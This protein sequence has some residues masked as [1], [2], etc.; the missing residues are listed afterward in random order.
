MKPVNCLK[1]SEECWTSRTRNSLI[2]WIRLTIQERFVNSVHRLL[3]T[4]LIILLPFSVHA[5][6]A[7]EVSPEIVSRALP[8]LEGLALQTLKKTGVPGMAIVVVHKDRVVYLKGFGVRKAG[9]DDPID[10]DTVFQLAS[11]SKP[12]TTTVLAALVGEGE[13]GWDDRVIDLDP[14]FRMYDP[15][16]TRQITLRDLL[17]H[18]SGLPAHVG[19]LLEDMGY[20]RTEILRR[21]RYAKPVS[22]FRSQYAY[23]NFG[24]TAAAVAAAQVT[25]K[26][27]EDLVAEKLYIP[28]GM[29]SSSSRFT[30]FSAAENRALLHARI[31][32]TWVPRYVRNPDAQSPAG[33]VSS[34]AR[35]LAQWMRL[36][37]GDGM[38]EGKRIV[39]AKALNEAHRPQIVSGYNPKTNRTSFYGL[40]WNVSCDEKGR[41]F[42]SHSGAFVLGVRTEVVLLPSEQVGIAVL[43]NASPTGVPEGMTKSFFDL[44]LRGKIEK[45]WVDLGNRLF[46]EQMKTDTGYATDYSSP[47]APKSPALPFD[48]Y[49]GVFRN[50]YFGDM[51]IVEKDRALVL[52]MG[53]K[54]MPFALQ[55]W[56]RD[57]FIYQPVGESAGGLSGVT[58][59]V[60]QDGKATRVVIENL[61]IFG[62]GAFQRV[63]TTK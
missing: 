11:L 28:L 56:N 33:G 10:A 54:R 21:L 4:L 48:A 15:W 14:R 47:P 44:L 17:C 19:D 16:V 32:G 9:G 2:S 6:S 29:K 45:D 52:R 25:G 51:E 3:S 12:I 35:D 58:F 20:G 26:S 36:L 1:P 61:D 63:S 60:G 39:S 8:Q 50:A 40:G 38:F 43:S 7:S 5:G 27:W 46:T 57:V 41:V 55:H 59:Q 18:R 23:T 62:Q 22:S 53:P 30:D 34:T 31:N 13:I 37:L 49:I 24:F 42:W